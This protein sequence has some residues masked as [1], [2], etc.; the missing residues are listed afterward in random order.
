MNVR[1]ATAIAA[2]FNQCQNPVYDALFIAGPE[3]NR[4]F[5][6]VGD[7]QA[8][9]WRLEGVFAAMCGNTDRAKTWLVWWDKRNWADA[10]DNW[11]QL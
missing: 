1:Q 5:V 3:Y 4:L 11:N 8:I 10:G 6:A 2:C 9:A 7:V